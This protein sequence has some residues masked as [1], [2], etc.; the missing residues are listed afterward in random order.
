M[1]RSGLLPTLVLVCIASIGE[2]QTMALLPGTT[3]EVMNGTTVRLLSPVQWQF[4]SGSTCLNDGLI[5]LSPSATVQEAVG[6][7]IGGLGTERIQRTYAAPLSGTEPGGLGLTVSTV[8]APGAVTLERGH[9]PILEPGGAESTGRWF[10][11]SAD[12]NTGLDATVAFAY[13]PTQL[14]GVSETDQ[15]LHVLQANSF[16][17]AIPSSVNTGANEVDAIGLDSLGFL[18]TFTGALT[19]SIAERVRD[20]GAFLAPTLTETTTL[21]ITISTDLDRPVEVFDATGKRVLGLVLPAGAPRISITVADLAP[22]VYTVHLGGS[23]SLRFI[24]S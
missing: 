8:G 7:P 13:D 11:W 22:G 19:T 6:A 18:T 9:A 14:N 15:V 12:V 17:Q 4:Q 3:L 23:R 20:E 2:A 21:L 10:H 5:E 1:F 16:W 24:R